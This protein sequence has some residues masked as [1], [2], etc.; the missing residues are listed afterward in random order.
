MQGI[1]T[2]A[3]DVVQDV[4]SAINAFG[5]LTILSNTTVLKQ[6]LSIDLENR[7]QITQF[8]RGAFFNGALCV[9]K[10]SALCQSYENER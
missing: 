9:F 1:P 7:K 2:I 8:K 10:F 3:S 5:I 6:V 4:H